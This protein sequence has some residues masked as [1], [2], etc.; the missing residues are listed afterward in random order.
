[1]AST[2]F[3]S[4]TYI[5]SNGVIAQS[6]YATA[7][8]VYCVTAYSTLYNCS[9]T[10]CD[11]VPN[12]PNPCNLS[13][14]ISQVNTPA[15][16]GLIANA[17]GGTPSY[18]Y[19]WSNGS[20]TQVIT[21][22]SPGNYCVTVTDSAGCYASSCFNYTGNNQNFGTLC[23]VVF[24]D[25]NANGIMDS[26]E[27]GIANAVIQIQGLGVSYTF[28]TNSN[29]FWSG[30]VPAGSYVVNYCSPAGSV[31]TIPLTNTGNF[32]NVNCTSVQVTVGAGQTLCGINFGVIQNT[33][34]ICGTV[35][36]DV[37]NDGIYNTGDNGMQNIPL[38][39]TGANGFVINTYTNS[40][41]SYCVNVPAGTY[42][43][44]IQPGVITGCAV[45]PV[46]LT[47]TG[48]AG[49]QL[50]GQNIAVYC[51]QNTCNVAVNVTPHTT[52]TPGFPAWYSLQVF[53]Y[54]SMPASG[55][56]NFFYDNALT[57]NYSSPAHTSHNASTKTISWNFTNLLPGQSKYYW[58]SFTSNTNL[59]IGQ[60]VFTLV[61]ANPNCNDVYYNNNVDTIHQ[62]VSASWDPN[63]K[64]AY[65]T[66]HDPNPAYH[67]ISSVNPNQRI[68][69]VINFQNT[70]NMPAVNVVVYDKISNDLDINSFQLLG[71]SHP[72]TVQRSGNEVY[73][74]FNN[75]MLPDSMSD[76]P[77]SHGFIKFAI[78]SINGLPV[79]HI[80]SDDAA[81]YFDYNAPVITNDA[82]VE[83]ITISA[84]DE[85]SSLPR[86]VI[87][88]NPMHQS[89]VFR[90]EGA[91][92]GFRLQVYDITGREVAAL[93]TPN[94]LLNFVRGN[95][96]NGIYTYQITTG[97][98]TSL[99]GKLVIE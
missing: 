78:N 97:N 3:G 59:T 53:N 43:I 69:Y 73:F 65:T 94:N 17:N 7:P 45:N 25:A 38:V 15:G 1:M 11:T 10:Y 16:P 27:I 8:G 99:R 2:G 61:N 44:T 36:F 5:W 31:T 29:G 87:A 91:E 57:Y 19:I 80:I 13:V 83:M 74:K 76:E 93:F 46:A 14:S 48:T 71:A 20:T 35:F 63:N 47:V 77:N 4:N 41:G 81:I 18:Q 23:G 49:Q 33:I 75:I 82:A 50:G 96:V 12:N 92:E 42:T 55:T 34:S 56:A 88:P 37:N 62:T 58:I 95:L 6:I 85:V 30:V 79:G 24:Y 32:S 98:R 70:G 86:V 51:Q 28:T 54:G 90:V 9:A 21:G 64:L 22:L 67:Y 89:A 68:E 39:I 84:L 52:V 40:N 60:P 72:M 26:T 66:N